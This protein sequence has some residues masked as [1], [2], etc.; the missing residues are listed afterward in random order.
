MVKHDYAILVLSC[1][2]YSALW[3]AFIDRF[4]KYWPDKLVNVYLVANN[5]RIEG[6]RFKPINIGED[7]DWSSN[8]IKALNYVVEDYVFITFDDVYFDAEVNS[9]ELNKI[10]NFIELN[11]PNYINTKAN[12]MPTIN[13]KSELVA[14]LEQG[15]HYRASLANAFWKKSVLK[16]LL[17]AGESAWDFEH[18]ASVRSNG[19]ES[20]Y[21][22]I[23]PLIKFKHIIIRGKIVWDCIKL[24]DVEGTSIEETFEKMKLWDYIKSNIMILR[25]KLYVRLIPKK[26][27][28]VIR[29]AF[30]RN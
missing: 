20:F 14:T 12:P 19:Y 2:K 1:D 21:G 26:Y 3:P 9:I 17:V 27:Q 5:K 23:K 24:K 7:K 11:N 8:L 6:T 13:I 16:E 30:K 22:T 10:I 25:G 4:N 28:Q 29:H 15:M 18:D